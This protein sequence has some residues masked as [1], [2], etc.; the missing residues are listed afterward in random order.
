ML[1]FMEPTRGS[2]S[3]E[4]VEPLNKCQL[5]QQIVHIIFDPKDKIASEFTKHSPIKP[6]DKFVY[7]LLKVLINHLSRKLWKDTQM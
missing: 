1:I 5:L 4:A 6:N 3:M 2:P 7:V